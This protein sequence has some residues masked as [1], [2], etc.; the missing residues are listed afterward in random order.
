M[1]NKKH[2]QTG[3]ILALV[4]S[5]LLLLAVSF[6]GCAT[7]NT[8]ADLTEPLK[9]ITNIS[10]S[11]TE[12]SI[13]V[14]IEGDSQLVYSA[15]KTTDPRGVKLDFSSTRILIDGAGRSLPANDMVSG[16]DATENTD[17]NQTISSVFITLKEDVPYRLTPT[18]SGIRV[19]F[20]KSRE[21][22]LQEKKAAHKVEPVSP[23]STNQLDKIIAEPGENRL[24]VLIEAGGAIQNY[25]AFTLENPPRIVVD[26][27]DLK[28]PFGRM[29]KVKVESAY[30]QQIRHFAH[31]EKVR[32]VLD[33]QRGF[34]K[35][36]AVTS[37]NS[38]LRMVVGEP[39]E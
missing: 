8:D 15:Y 30:V 10:M 35:K 32:L 4:L 25:K 22:N 12:E 13:N 17:G 39:A 21:P 7:L 18:D 20:P 5:I 11:E 24:V 2:F 28:S 38:G 26:M 1:E 29:Q 33:T 37:T 19:A 6:M 9:K 34:L 27:F 23:P 16:I 3:L 14:F 36:Y 31:P